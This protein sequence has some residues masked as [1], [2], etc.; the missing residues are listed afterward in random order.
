M[1]IFKISLDLPFLDETTVHL[2]WKIHGSENGN[3]GQDETEL[4]YHR[5]VNMTRDTR[6]ESLQLLYLNGST[7]FHRVFR[8]EFE[9]SENGN[10][11]QNNDKLLNRVKDLSNLF[12]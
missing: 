9:G 2:P 6:K 8:K 11:R 1:V 3:F 5:W 12:S 7:R 4:P 10:S